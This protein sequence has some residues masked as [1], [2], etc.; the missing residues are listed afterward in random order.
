M[1]N[2]RCLQ[3]CGVRGGVLVKVVPGKSQ[4][5]TYNQRLAKHPAREHLLISSLVVG[6][7]ST[8]DSAYLQKQGAGAHAGSQQYPPQGHM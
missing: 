5:H 2:D 7:I 8:R 3:E 4:T 6:R 1:Q